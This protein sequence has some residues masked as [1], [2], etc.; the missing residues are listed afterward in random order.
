MGVALAYAVTVGA[1]G[2]SGDQAIAPG[3]PA[4][5]PNEPTEIRVHTATAGRNLDPD[6]YLVTL[7]GQE[8]RAIGLNDLLTFTNVVDRPAR[9]GTHRGFGELGNEASIPP[10]R[11]A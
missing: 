1:L 6:G 3:A 10:S 7:D 9:G 2:C 4:E 8:K 5:L 11:A